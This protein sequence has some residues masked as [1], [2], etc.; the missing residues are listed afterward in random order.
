MPFKRS[1]HVRPPPSALETRM[2]TGWKFWQ[3]TGEENVGRFNRVKSSG[4]IINSQAIPS[5]AHLCAHPRSSI[6][7]HDLQTRERERGY[8]GPLCWGN[9][10]TLNLHWKR[11]FGGCNLGKRSVESGLRFTVNIGEKTIGATFRRWSVRG[12]LRS[13]VGY[14][15]VGKL[16]PVYYRINFITRFRYGG[17]WIYTGNRIFEDFPASVRDNKC[18]YGIVGQFRFSKFIYLF[19]QHIYLFILLFEA[20]LCGKFWKLILPRFQINFNTI[21]LLCLG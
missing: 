15:I 9:N 7:K 8:N 6:I 18:Y 10:N 12:F 4:R 13:R 3:W 5:S 20:T 2:E 21:L 11:L 17:R 14:K 19:S 16:I 1:R